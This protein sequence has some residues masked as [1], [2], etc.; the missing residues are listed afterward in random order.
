MNTPHT[1]AA[2][3]SVALVGANGSPIVVETDIKAGL[4][5]VQIVGMGNKAIN[6]ARQRVRSAVTNSQL[7]FPA[8]KIVVNLAPA[9]LPKDGTHLD[10]PIAISILVASG[11]LRSQEVAST[12]FAGELA[13][14]GLLRP[15]RGGISITEAALALGVTRVFLP[16]VTA[17]QA[18]LVPGTLEVVPVT[19]LTEVFKILKGRPSAPPYRAIHPKSHP[20]RS[21]P[22]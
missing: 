18:Q 7:T 8:R 9:E 19:S 4:P 12:V 16:T 22:R 21:Y 15:I 6:E 20:S 1:V 11:Q 3:N 5:G 10:L 14:D 2:I 13:L 17:Q